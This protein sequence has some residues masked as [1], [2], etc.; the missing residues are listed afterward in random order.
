MGMVIRFS[1]DSRV[2][3]LALFGV[4]ASGAEVKNLG[5]MEA[6][7][8]GSGDCLAGWWGTTAVL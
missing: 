1:S 5:V 2:E 3:S 7:M 6:S 8:V 4:L